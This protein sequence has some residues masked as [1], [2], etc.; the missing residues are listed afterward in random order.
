[1]CAALEE[2]GADTVYSDVPVGIGLDFDFDLLV[3]LYAGAVV[4]DVVVS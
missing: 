2:V 4:V 1:V 3:A